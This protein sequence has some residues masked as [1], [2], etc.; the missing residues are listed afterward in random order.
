MSLFFMSTGLKLPGCWFSVRKKRRKKRF[1]QVISGTRRLWIKELKAHNQFTSCSLSVCLHTHSLVFFCF[2]I[3]LFFSK[4][5]VPLKSPGSLFQPHWV[6][7]V[8]FSFFGGEGVR[9]NRNKRF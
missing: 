7:L 1:L 4:F 3:L 9:L 2:S 6:F 5:L 8:F